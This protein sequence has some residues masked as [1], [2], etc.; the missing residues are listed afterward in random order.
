MSDDSLQ[1]GT[2]EVLRQR[3]LDGASQLR[4]RFDRLNDQRS[5]VFGNLETRLLTTVHVTTDHN[6]I[7]RDLISVGSH[8][9]LGY[10]V[11]FGLKSDVV[12]SDVLSLY[13]VDDE[14]AVQ[15]PLTTWVD[16]RFTRDFADLYRYYKH[17]FF[18]CFFQQG[19][20][21]YMVFQVGKTHQDIKAFKWVSD[22]SSLRYVDNRSDQEIKYPEQHDFRWLRATRDQHRSG[23]HP[24]VSIGDIVF[25][26]CIGGD[27]TIKVE[28]KHDFRQRHLQRTGRPQRPN[29]GRR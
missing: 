21:V 12:P 18:S 25:V 29:A 23:L 15:V 4:E 3:L 13:R 19:P 28:D 5:E 24:H 6:C 16:E 27:L 17:T 8:L 14:H 10:N 1:V 20:Y 9:L 22:G 11:Q 26:E 2:Y 7:P